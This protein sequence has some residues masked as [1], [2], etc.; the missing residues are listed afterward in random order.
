MKIGLVCPYDLF[1]GGG[2]QEHVLAQAD[3]LR[4][5]GH[6]VKIMTP[7]V[8][9][10]EGRKPKNI[11][12][13][14]NSAKVRTP[15]KT[16]HEWGAIIKRDGV[17]DI[18]AREKFDVIHIHEPEVP[19]IGAQIVAYATCP[20]VATFHA[21]FPDTVAGRTIEAIRVMYSRAVYD[22]LTEITSVTNDA[23]NFVRERTGRKVNI[24]PNGIDLKKFSQAEAHE[25]MP[26]DLKT[27]LYVGRLEK[28]KGVKYLIKA[29]EKLAQQHSDV[30]LIIAGNGEERE[31]LEDIVSFRDIPRVSFLGFVSEA[32]KIQLLNKADLFCAPALYG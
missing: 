12:F 25:K 18:L 11:I 28:R 13:V 9:G 8:F 22:H 14:G 7:K 17:E 2:V 4:R 16:S 26:G 24:I 3:E 10:Y 19:I 30:Q 23:A 31:K 32:K 21:L 27:I 15:I 29:Y 5:R 20:I 6:T 1:R